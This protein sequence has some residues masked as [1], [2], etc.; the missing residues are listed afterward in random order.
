MENK[1]SSDSMFRKYWWLEV[2]LDPEDLRIHLYKLKG[3]EDA[4]KEIVK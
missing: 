4:V 3:P 2:R 1:Q